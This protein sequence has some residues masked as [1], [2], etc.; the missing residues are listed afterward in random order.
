MCD[1]CLNS[2]EKNK[3]TDGMGVHWCEECNERLSDNDDEQY[4]GDNIIIFPTKGEEITTTL[5]EIQS[6]TVHQC[7][8]GCDTFFI[9]DKGD[10]MCSECWSEEVEE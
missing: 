5:E 10:A 7:I 2:N 3:Y 1:F 6:M 9:S 8:C 4:E